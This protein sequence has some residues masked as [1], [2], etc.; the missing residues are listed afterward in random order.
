M[1]QFTVSI[2]IPIYN[3]E[4]F[5][6]ETINSVLNQTYKNIEVIL[7]DDHSTDGSYDLAE[8][9]KDEKITLV[10]NPKKGACAARNYGFELSTGDYIQYLDADDLLSLH[11]IEKQLQQ[12]Q[13]F[14]N[15]IICSGVWGR[16][17][18]SVSEVIWEQ[19]DINKDYENPIEWLIDSWS[20]KGMMAVHCWLV[21]RE[22]IKKAGPWNENLLLNQ[23]GEF[24]SRVLLNA[25]AIKFCKNAEV[26]YRSGN[27][28]S[29]SQ[30]NQLSIE[31]ASS[32]LESFELYQK[33]C[34]D[35]IELETVK[36]GLG[37]NYLNFMYQFYPLFPELLKRA[38]VQFYALG[39][40]KM[41]TVG[42]EKFKKLANFIGF[43]NALKLK[44][45][46]N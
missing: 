5:L 30:Q 38:E 1:K 37:E 43:K 14:G 9:F 26:Y 3:A 11:K 10:K 42:G 7:V 27:V 34:Q 45:L 20:G 24:F 2:I 15:N 28:N 22:I 8:Q 18:D 16:F 39:H 6:A 17:H 25:K 19:H 32:L 29:I 4:D 44:K 40:H 12:F 41:W 33:N 46:L 36:K 35:Y 21:P 13:Q 31:K 23:D